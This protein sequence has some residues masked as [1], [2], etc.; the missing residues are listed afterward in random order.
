MIEIPLRRRGRGVVAVA[1][2]DDEDAHLATYTWHISAYGYV[3]RNV[4]VGTRS[5]HRDVL[6]LATG[7]PRQGDHING[8]KFDNRRVNLRVVTHAQNNQNQPSSRGSSSRFRGVVRSGNR[9]RAHTRWQGRL[10]HHGYFD[11]EEDAAA[12][13]SAF[14]KEHMP[15]ARD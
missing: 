8:D 1:L 13:A 9:W 2:I 4:V 14:R 6:G 15:Y 3:H 7:D 11:R 5:L 12:A 10:H